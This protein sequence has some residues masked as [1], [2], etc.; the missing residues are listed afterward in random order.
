MV[1]SKVLSMIERSP[2]APVPRRIDVA[3]I[4]RTAPSVKVSFTPSTANSFLI[5]LD[6][7]VL[8]F[9]EDTR[10]IILGKLLQ[11]A[12]HRQPAYEFR[13]QTEIGQIVSGH[14][15]EQFPLRHLMI[16]PGCAETAFPGTQALRH[17]VVKPHERAA[18]DEQDVSGINPHGLHLAVLAGSL[19]RHGGDGAFQDLEQCLLHALAGHIACDGRVLAAFTGDFV[20]LIYNMTPCSA[21]ATSPSA[22]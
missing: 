17:D 4:C 15:R 13:K 1:S 6:Q 20:D 3:A 8:R 16:V 5:L 18:T 2:R 10:Q 7:R 12:D 22:A 21:R 19:Y 11:H 14:L 9:D